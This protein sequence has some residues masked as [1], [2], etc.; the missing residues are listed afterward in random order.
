ME[1]MATGYDNE[2]GE[3]VDSLINCMIEPLKEMSEMGRGS[4]VARQVRV[5]CRS[6]SKF[7]EQVKYSLEAHH[8]D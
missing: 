1:C 5:K 3:L 8:K 2:R 7:N 4:L 6:K